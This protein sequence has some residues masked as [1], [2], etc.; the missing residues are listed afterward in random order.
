MKPIEFPEQTC[1]YAKDQP[2]YEPLPVHKTHEGIVTSCWK[3]TWRERLR[4]LWTGKV[5]CSTL[6][7]NSPLQ[8]QLLLATSPFCK[9]DT[10]PSGLSNQ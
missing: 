2:E 8:P 3:F 4:V 7:F 5:W 1:V 9:P 6:T 10:A